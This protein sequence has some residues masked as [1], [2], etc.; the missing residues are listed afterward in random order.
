MH[1]GALKVLDLTASLLLS[2]L[3]ISLTALQFLL[4]G[5]GDWAKAKKQQLQKRPNRFSID[6][7]PLPSRASASLTVHS[8]RIALVII[9]LQRMTS[10]FFP[11]PCTLYTVILKLARKGGL[12]S[13]DTVPC[14]G[15]AH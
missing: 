1:P 2:F 10:V 3:V 4:H 5:E 9:P 7:H 8:A 13:S 11:V 12:S 14:V 6:V 15:T